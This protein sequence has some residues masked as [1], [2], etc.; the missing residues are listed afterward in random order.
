M[1]T[2]K[3]AGCTVAYEPKYRLMQEKMEQ[4]A[5]P[6]KPGQEADIQITLPDPFLEEKAQ[7]SALTLAECEYVWAGAI[8]YRKLLKFGGML[9]HASA[10]EVENTAY[11][12]SADSG[13]GK[14]THVKF[15][16]EWMGKDRAVILNDDK[17]AVRIEGG[18]CVAWGTPFS[19]KS[20]EHLNRRA[21]IGGICMLERGEENRIWRIDPR[22][23]LPLLM[24]QTVWPKQKEEADRLLDLLE[25]LLD[26]VPVYR[27][28]CTCS[29]DAAKTAFADMRRG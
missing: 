10:V 22:E 20:P 6:L 3:I 5:Y 23:A 1:K 21:R 25:Q 7:N 14:S 11:L 19:G 12:F 2:Y 17:P 18:E 26:K 27:M 15:W 9:L 29:M 8:F 16:Q 13:V 24:R 28:A 4:Y